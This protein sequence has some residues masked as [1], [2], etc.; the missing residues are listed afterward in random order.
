MKFPKG[1]N[2]STRIPKYEFNSP[3]GLEF[4]LSSIKAIYKKSKEK[5]SGP[6]RQNFYGL[7]YFANSFGKYNVDFKEYD[8]VKGDVL[9]IS[10]EQVHFF[11]N[12][13][14]TRGDVLLF[15]S[16]FLNSDSIVDLI[17]E[18]N[19]GNPILSLNKPFIEIFEALI[20]HIK[21]KFSSNEK[22]KREILK[23]YLEIILLE[24][25]QNSKENALE[26]SKDHRRFI[27]FKKD[28]K[29]HF[30][31]HKNVKFYADKQF[32]SAKTLNI[33]IRQVLNQ[34][35]KQFINDYIIL[36]AKRMLIN[37]SDTN[38]EIAYNLGFKEPTNFTKF[39]KNRE[40]TSPSMF[41]KLHNT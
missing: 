10:N 20:L 21:S 33:A 39:F 26:Q 31:N 8:I 41:Q 28:L 30:K 3:Q 14:K 27:Q 13:E 9:F 2:L 24:I 23:R 5:L 35:S 11:K 7:F 22:M 25:Y 12:I 16:S 18:Q 38:A 4:E 32:I 15:T 29:I 36:V 1:Q 19:I 40:G 17:F 34:S 37:S 6:H